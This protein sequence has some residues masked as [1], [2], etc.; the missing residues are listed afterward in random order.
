[1]HG[2]EGA[3][4][5]GVQQR[6]VC[7][8]CT[9]RGAVAEATAMGVWA[10]RGASGGV[11]CVPQGRPMRVPCKVTC[12]SDLGWWGHIRWCD[13]CA[14][15]WTHECCAMLHMH[16]RQAG[17]SGHREV[18]LDM[19]RHVQIV[20]NTS[21][22]GKKK[23]TH[24][25][26]WAGTWRHGKMQ[27]GRCRHRRQAWADVGGWWCC[28]HATRQTHKGAMQCHTHI[29]GRPMRAPY[30]VMQ[31]Y[32]EGQLEGVQTGVWCMNSGSHRGCH[33]CIVPDNT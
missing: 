9:F 27:V 1:M 33:L 3:V 31:A 32:E 4:A 12:T 11:A 2:M 26:A 15:R 20:M 8:A 23:H 25:Q 14:I 10:L 28:M 18:Q 5:G 7:G 19:C 29:W 16:V 21:R 30:N 13:I 6:L 24:P 22:K 17:A